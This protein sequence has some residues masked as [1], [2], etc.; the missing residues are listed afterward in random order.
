MMWP[1]RILLSI[2]VATILVATA[3]AEIRSK[4]VEYKQ[5]DAT[6]EGRLTYDDSLPGKRP[7]LLVVHQWMGLGSYGGAVHSFTLW[8]AG[9]DNSRGAAYNEKADKRSWEAMKSF[10][11]EIFP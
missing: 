5:G 9:A 3:R 1:M 10:F 6:L 7:G 11:A 4:S 2:C 8:E